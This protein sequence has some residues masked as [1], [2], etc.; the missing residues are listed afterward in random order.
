MTGSKAMKRD[1]VPPQEGLHIE[2]STVAPD[3]ILVLPVDATELGDNLVP[4]EAVSYAFFRY[5]D[6]GA[7]FVGP[8]VFLSLDPVVATGDEMIA[9]G[10]L[11]QANVDFWAERGATSFGLVAWGPETNG[12]E[13]DMIVPLLGQIVLAERGTG[14]QV[15]PETVGMEVR[16]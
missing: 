5:G 9:A 3:T 7:E 8:H 6:D 14:R 2:F 12:S 15:W 1:D 10:R 13:G 11:D 4:D 16:P